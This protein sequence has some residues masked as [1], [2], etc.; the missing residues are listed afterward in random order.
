MGG[1]ISKGIYWTAPVPG[2]LAGQSAALAYAQGARTPAEIA[3]QG[4]KNFFLQLVGMGIVICILLALT[5][6]F[7]KPSAPPTKEK[8]T[9]RF[10]DPT[11]AEYDQ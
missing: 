9:N 2:G 11:E 3:A 1:E 7:A 4:M 5:H 10:L 6:I 8:Y